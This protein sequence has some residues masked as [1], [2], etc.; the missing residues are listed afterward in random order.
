[1]TTC[2]YR[3]CLCFSCFILLDNLQFVTEVTWRVYAIQIILVRLHNAV[4]SLKSFGRTPKMSDKQMGNIW[5]NDFAASDCLATGI[6][7]LLFSWPDILALDVLVLDLPP[8]SLGN[9]KIYLGCKY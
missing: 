2:Q 7:P 9:P 8:N 1:M 3:L 4:G 5:K 6:L